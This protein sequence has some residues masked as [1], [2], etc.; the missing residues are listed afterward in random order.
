MKKIFFCNLCLVLLMAGLFSFS[1]CTKNSGSLPI[2]LLCEYKTAPLGIEM[3]NPRF[4]WQ[5]KTSERGVSQTAFRILVAS[6]PTLLKQEKGDIWDS[7]KIECCNSTL[8]DYTG[9]DLQ[10]STCYYWAVQIWDQD[11]LPTKW[12]APAC[13]ETGFF[14]PSEEWKAQWI[15]SGDTIVPLRSIALRKEFNVSK[16]IESA[17]LYVTGLGNYVARI[18][19]EKVGADML[20]PA[21]TEYATRLNYQIY[22]VTSMLNEGT[23]AIGATLGN[24]WWSSGMGWADAN[25][26]HTKND[27]LRLLAQL[28][29]S[30]ADGSSEMVLTDNS[31]TTAPSPIV[32]DHI[33]HGEHYDATLEQCGWDKPNFDNGTWTAA[34]VL[35]NLD[36][37]LTL[38]AQREEPIRITRELKPVEMWKAENGDYVYDMG[39][40]MVGL[41]RVKITGE[42]GK[43]VIIRYA[44]LLHPDRTIAQ[45]NLRTA[46]VTD[47]YTKKSDDEEIYTPSFVYHGFRYVQIAGLES[48]DESTITGLV[49]NTDAK[50]VGS[51]ECSNDMLNKIWSNSFWGLRGN[52]MSAPTDCP[53]RDE[54][55]GWTGDG[56]IFAPTAF[57]NMRLSNFYAKWARD[58]RD[59]QSDEGWIGDFHPIFGKVTHPGK[60]AWADAIAVVPWRIYE[61]YGDKRVLEE[62][63]DAIKAWVDYM[64]SVAKNDVY[65]WD[66]NTNWFGYGDWVPVVASP[67]KPIGGLYYYYSTEVLAK[68]AK[69][70]GKDDDAK[71]YSDRLPVIA[72]GYQKAYYNTA[73]QQYEG[74]TQ[75]ANLLPIYFGITPE[76]QKA[77]VFENLVANIHQYDDHLTT[78]FI[79]SAYLLPLLSE[80]GQHELAYKVANQRTYPSWGYMVDKGATTI[81]ELWNSDTERPEGMNSRNHFTY[82]SVAAWYYGYLAGIRPIME[83]PGFKKFIIAPMPAGDLTSVNASTE[84]LYGIISSQWEKIGDNFTLAITIPANTTAKVSVPAT[85]SSVITEA[86]KELVN[87][88][89]AGATDKNITFVELRDGRAYF[90]VASGT[91]KFDVK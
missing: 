38:Q 15:G 3:Q 88:G 77:A 59:G 63:Y 65:A 71:K 56:Q 14:N 24:M 75:S 30:Y 50:E 5:I 66:N 18:N 44:E 1:S 2:N 17:R 51:F 84:T 47:K 49:F 67:T 46:I 11:G 19:G 74:K 43:T 60:P 86:G 83:A 76:D 45:E 87:A 39:Q 40:N 16:P 57:Y 53:Q 23:N 6:S 54:R 33:Y 9:Q 8:V 4:G 12:S 79:G 68:A 81:W 13:F 10:S 36:A 69:V 72:K 55:L 85:E 61:F 37:N 32:Y 21:W 27:P 91:Y 90:N 52:I 62:N 70:L 22:D 42:K 80:N 20:T 25:M 31:W 78:G 82:G 28:Q 89:Q 73:A 29:I 7:Q 48:A 34:V 35:D 58:M 41:A 64:Y 26:R